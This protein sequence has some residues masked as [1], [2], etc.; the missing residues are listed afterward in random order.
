MQHDSHH[1]A[2][3][4]TLLLLEFIAL[5]EYIDEISGD[6]AHRQLTEVFGFSLEAGFPGDLPPFAYGV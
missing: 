2:R 4:W 1:S 6:W 5:K 3:L